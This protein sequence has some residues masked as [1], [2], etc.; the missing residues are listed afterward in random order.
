MMSDPRPGVPYILV[1]QDQDESLTL[2]R[3]EPEKPTRRIR[4]VGD[5]AKRAWQLF[6]NMFGE[7]Q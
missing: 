3:H 7:R 6:N 2:E 4:L 1:S 5:M